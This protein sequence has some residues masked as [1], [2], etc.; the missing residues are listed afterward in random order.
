[1]RPLPPYTLPQYPEA[2]KAIS[3]RARFLYGSINHL[4]RQVGL[5]RQAFHA[6]ANLATFST[7]THPWFEFVLHLPQG[8]L[9]EGVPDHELTRPVLPAALV[10]GLAASDDAWVSRPGF[11]PRRSQGEG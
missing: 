6:R 8:S 2:Q 11:R 7:S 10:Y 9:A 4:A 5:T 3:A 1:M